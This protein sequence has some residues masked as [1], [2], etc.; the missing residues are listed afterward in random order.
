[1]IPISVSD[2]DGY[3]Y[4]RGPEHSTDGRMEEAR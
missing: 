3:R 1:M 2:L 4:W